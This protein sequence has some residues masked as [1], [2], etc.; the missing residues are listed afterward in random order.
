MATF[1]DSL[2][3]MTH[4][5]APPSERSSPAGGASDDAKLAR[6]EQLERVLLQEV[7]DLQLRGR[8]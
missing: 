1:A 3:A 4:A 6:L 2:A 5:N 8:Y 7:E